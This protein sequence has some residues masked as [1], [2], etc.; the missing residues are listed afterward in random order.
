MRRSWHDRRMPADDARLFPPVL[1]AVPTTGTLEAAEL[2]ACVLDGDL[3]RV[4][5]AFVPIDAPIG[6]VDRAL[7][8][9]PVLPRRAIL[10]RRS[11]A[12]VW[13]A[14][15]QLEEPLSLYVRS[16]SPSVARDPLRT[17]VHE[18]SLAAD[19][20]VVLGGLELT[21][22]LRTAVDLACAREGEFDQ[23][24]LQR[25]LRRSGLTVTEVEA[26]LARR[27]RIP[28]RRWALRRL[29]VLFTR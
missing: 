10:A 5:D 24:G 23:Q 6:R 19:D 29:Q 13:G 18:V 28:G 26:S 7:A 22:P 1:T 16:E 25:L 11:A 3:L 4:G 2:A 9:P 12:W 21:S 17:R 27:P 20:V 15:W 14:L 8:I